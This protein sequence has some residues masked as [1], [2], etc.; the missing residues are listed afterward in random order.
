MT[1]YTK[2]DEVRDY[3]EMAVYI[4]GIAAVIITSLTV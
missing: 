1:A 4:I 2:G 3:I